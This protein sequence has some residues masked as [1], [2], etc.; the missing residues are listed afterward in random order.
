MNDIFISHASEDK[1]AIARPLAAVLRARGFSVWYDEYE[2][3]VGDSIRAGIDR[4]LGSCRFAVLILSRS[5]FVKS[6]AQWELNALLHVEASRKAQFVLPIWH[7]VTRTDVAQFSPI[8]ADR[9]AV[10]SDTGIDAIVA[11]LLRVLHGEESAVE[12]DPLADYEVLYTV[13]QAH[14]GRVLKCR[15]KSDHALCIVKESESRC[16]DLAALRL[17]TTVQVENLA[18]PSKVWQAGRFTYE[19]LPYVGGIR[20]SQAVVPQIGGLTGSVLESCHR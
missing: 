11:S 14:Y 1:D 15:R 5:Y 2:L 10:T 7:E 16:V 13:H 4:G 6:W 17:L 12:T 8:L 18:S 3:R 20:L 9:V 19:E